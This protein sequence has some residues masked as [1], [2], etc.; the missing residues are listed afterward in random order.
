MA[1]KVIKDELYPGWEQYVGKAE[2]CVVNFNIPFPDQADWFFG[3]YVDRTISAAQ[4]AV[5]QE[6][7]HILRT[8]VLR[9]KSPTME[10]PYQIQ[11]TAYTNPTILVWAAIYGVMFLILAVIVAWTI[12]QIVSVD[13]GEIMPPI[14]EAMKWA[15]IAII[16]G[17]TAAVALALI[18][19][20]RKAHV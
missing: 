8:V 11:I 16:G 19:S 13:W 4:E 5:E 7:G 9:D 3:R 1:L 18:L 10:T 14:P 15:A 12:K 20:R 2:T 6:G 17:G